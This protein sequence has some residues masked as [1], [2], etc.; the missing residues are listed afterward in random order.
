MRKMINLIEGEQPDLFADDEEGVRSRSAAVAHRAKALGIPVVD[1]PLSDAERDAALGVVWPP[2]EAED[3]DAQL[4]KVFNDAMLK[5]RLRRQV[6]DVYLLVLDDFPFEDAV[7]QV[8]KRDNMDPLDLRAA[9]VDDYKILR[10]QADTYASYAGNQLVH[11]LNPIIREAI[12][13]SL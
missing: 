7:S 8:A 4:D 12:E 5:L 1:V 9:C 13:R 11:A 2:V 3:F 10:S 6:E